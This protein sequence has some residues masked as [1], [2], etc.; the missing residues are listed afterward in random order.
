MPL[1]WFLWL[2]HF[3][4]VMPKICSWGYAISLCCLNHEWNMLKHP[5]STSQLRS[6]SNRKKKRLRSRSNYMPLDLDIQ[7][8]I[9]ELNMLPLFSMDHETF[10]HRP[11]IC[12]CHDTRT[13]DRSFRRFQNQPP[14]RRRCTDAES[15]P[16]AE[17]QAVGGNRRGLGA[18]CRV[19]CGSCMGMRR[20]GAA[21]RVRRHSHWRSVL[22]SVSFHWA[23]TNW[24]RATVP[25]Q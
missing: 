8:S 2:V 11:T 16:A 17:C 23:D 25:V 13:S 24:T 15:A 21:D 12:R 4:S 3:F 10:S 9:Y 20:R 18:W 22:L 1:W 6:R 19:A 14:I 7:L 5:R